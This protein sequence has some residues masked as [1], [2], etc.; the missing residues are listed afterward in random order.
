MLISGL[1]ALFWSMGMSLGLLPISAVS[2]PFLSFGGSQLLAQL[3]AI[4][5]IYSVYRRKDMISLKGRI[6]NG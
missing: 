4:G 2:F 5:L 1:G 3:A 6:R